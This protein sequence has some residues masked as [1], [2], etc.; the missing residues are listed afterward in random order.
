MLE[1]PQTLNPYAYAL[2][3]PLKYTDPTGHRAKTQDSD[4]RDVPCGPLRPCYESEVTTKAELSTGMSEFFWKNV[5]DTLEG[6]DSLN[7][8][9]LSGIS[10]S[11]VPVAGDLADGGLIARDVSYGN[12]PSMFDVGATLIPFLG[13]AHKRAAAKGLDEASDLLSGICFVGGTLVETEYGQVPIEQIT[14]GM[15]VLARD[16]DS[17]QVNWKQVTRVFVTAD[18]PVFDLHLVDETNRVETLGVTR[19]HP[20]WVTDRG[21][22]P[23][24]ALNPGDDLHSAAGTSVTVA[25]HPCETTFL[26]A[27]YG[28]EV[29]GYHTYF[30]GESSVWVHNKSKADNLDLPSL[31]GTGKVH[32]KLPGAGDLGQY[33][34][35][36]LRQLLAELKASVQQRIQTNIQ[37]GSDKAHAQ[38]QANE[39]KLIRQ[40]EKY[41][42]GS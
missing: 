21:W 20:F 13:V 15:F 16:L 11:G 42:G 38:R 39:Q 41:L 36:E 37:K 8:Y 33:S 28:L 14:P 25:Q 24:Y 4:S 2:G 29:D 22:V 5:W 10:M 17:G 23:A 1:N 9:V 19:E 30:V 7:V 12:A 31:D 40:I 32:G 18:Q 3:N 35:E 34:K 27:V 26:E 6:V